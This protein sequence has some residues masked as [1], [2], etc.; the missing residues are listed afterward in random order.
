M[1][2]RR[3]LA[4]SA[5]PGAASTGGLTFAVKFET[6]CGCRG[7]EDDRP[8]NFRVIHILAE[9]TGPCKQMPA[10]CQLSSHGSILGARQMIG[11]C[12]RTDPE[13]PIFANYM[14]TDYHADT[15]HSSQPSNTLS[16]KT[17]SCT[18]QRV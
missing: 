2:L 7:S 15:Q 17:L 14:I 16:R 8:L 9:Y 18:V 12:A 4:T 1:G 13:H 11:K 3:K 10:Q 6:C 5:G